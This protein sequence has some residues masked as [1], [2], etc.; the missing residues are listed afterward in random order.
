MRGGVRCPREMGVGPFSCLVHTILLMLWVSTVQNRFSLTGMSFAECS[1]QLLQAQAFT[2]LVGVHH[3]HAPTRRVGPVWELLH[4]SVLVHRR[5]SAAAS[6]SSTDT[7][8]GRGGEQAEQVFGLTTS[9]GE[10][11]VK[12]PGARP[13]LTRS[14][15]ARSTSGRL[16]G[17][18]VSSLGMWSSPHE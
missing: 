8:G 9:S 16:V 4:R 18:S 7:K 2:Y 10:E 14:R 13:R 17:P 6:S 11:F 15:L 3:R 5:D 1:Y 12:S